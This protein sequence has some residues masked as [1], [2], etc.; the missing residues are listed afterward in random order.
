[1]LQYST[2]KGSDSQS[3]QNQRIL[4]IIQYRL[5][6]MKELVGKDGKEVLK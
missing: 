4:F 2:S 1:M 3:K 6:E 5:Y